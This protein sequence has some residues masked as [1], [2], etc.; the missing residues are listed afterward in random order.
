M[1]PSVLGSDVYRSISSALPGRSAAWRAYCR[2]NDSSSSSDSGVSAAAGFPRSVIMTGS[3][4]IVY[5]S[6]S[7]VLFFSST[8]L[9][10]RIAC[11]LQT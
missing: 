4:A 11:A 3:P 5:R 7:L 10:T 6:S 8:V 1:V 9:A 2:T